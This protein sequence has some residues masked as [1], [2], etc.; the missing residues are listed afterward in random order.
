M[1]DKGVKLAANA[2]CN[3]SLETA[4]TE[5]PGYAEIERDLVGFFKGLEGARRWAA[6]SF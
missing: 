3:P 6:A 4:V 1:F 5:D 2:R